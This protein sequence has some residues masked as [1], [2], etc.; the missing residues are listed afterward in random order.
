MQVHKAWQF[1][2]FN[3]NKGYFTG[4]KGQ[5]M[6]GELDRAQVFRTKSEA[7]MAAL[8]VK[9]ILELESVLIWHRDVH[10]NSTSEELCSLSNTSNRFSNSNAAVH[11]ESTSD[12][13]S[14]TKLRLVK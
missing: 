5:E 1:L 8:G 7:H 11:N 14:K 4:Y 12:F 9:E 10:S 3:V 6:F 13:K 2:L